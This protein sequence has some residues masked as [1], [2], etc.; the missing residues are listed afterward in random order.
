MTNEKKKKDAIVDI[1]K[2]EFISNELRKISSPEVKKGYLKFAC[3]SPEDKVTL[4]ATYS[5][6]FPED[7][8][9]LDFIASEIEADV[10]ER[11]ESK[12]GTT[13]AF[14]PLNIYKC[15]KELAEDLAILYGRAFKLAIENLE[16]LAPRK[17]DELADEMPEAY[18]PYLMSGAE[19]EKEYYTVVDKAKTE[20]KAEV[21][22][23][24][25]G[26]VLKDK[27]HKPSLLSRIRGFFAKKS[28]KPKVEKI[29]LVDIG[30]VTPKDAKPRAEELESKKREAYEASLARRRKEKAA[31]YGPAEKSA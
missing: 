8:V 24:K 26:V 14:D 28:D 12:K 1:S 19:I 15:L 30:G 27:E 4:L 9:T 7:T 16:Y 3:S 20:A 29:S 2:F 25:K 21:E 31:T 23:D 5:A 6:N 22:R 17:K 13:F 11:D 18:M 10:K